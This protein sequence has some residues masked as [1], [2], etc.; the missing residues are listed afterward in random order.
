MNLSIT[1]HLWLLSIFTIISTLLASASNKTQEK[2]FLPIEITDNEQVFINFSY[3]KLNRIESISIKKCYQ[4]DSCYIT[5]ITYS[6]YDNDLVKEKNT[7]SL[8]KEA[9]PVD[10]IRAVYNEQFQYQISDTIIYKYLNKTTSVDN[11]RYTEDFDSVPDSK[12]YLNKR[13]FPYK[14]EDIDKSSFIKTTT[15]LDYDES[16][17]LIKNVQTM[18]NKYSELL[19]D[20]S[21]EVLESTTGK[22]I[23]AD[24]DYF[25]LM[26]TL[27]SIYG[28]NFSKYN[29]PTHVKRTIILN[30]DISTDGGIYS[31]E[32]NELGYPISIH[33][34]YLNNDKEESETTLYIQYEKR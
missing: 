17:M 25:N 13:G 4:P 14:T 26:Q 20:S 11:M 30:D 28:P 23:F 18:T 1:K 29:R 34:K 12:I 10:T 16:G 6:Y 24:I 19:Y 2:L 15:I 7:I 3:D 32:D 31:Y 9:K 27:N 33:L 21:F 8:I 5:E 22:N